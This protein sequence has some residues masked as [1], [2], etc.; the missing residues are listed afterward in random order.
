MAS[1]RL[2]LAPDPGDRSPICDRYC[3]CAR[4]VQGHRK[5]QSK[6]YEYGPHQLD[7]YGLLLYV[8]VW[9]TVRPC[10]VSPCAR[11]REKVRAVM[12]SL[13]APR[14]LSASYQSVGEAT[15]TALQRRTGDKPCMG[16]ARA[17]P[18][19]GV[20]GETVGACV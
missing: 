1:T 12:A 8:N 7:R 3:A 19:T 9:A 10:G 20:N 14:P 16:R 15:A 18:A 2:L 5:S 4:R 17:V 13:C 11:P 6:P